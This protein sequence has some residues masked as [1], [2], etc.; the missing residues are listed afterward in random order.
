MYLLPFVLPFLALPALAGKVTEIGLRRRH[1]QYKYS[2]NNDNVTNNGQVYK[3]KDIYKG[4]DF[5][6]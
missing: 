2:R 4:Q 5:L 3:L 1:L 6:E